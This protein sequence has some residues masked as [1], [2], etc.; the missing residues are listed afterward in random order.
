MSQVHTA[1][2]LPPKIDPQWLEVNLEEYKLLR[3]EL[4]QRLKDADTFNVRAFRL[5]AGAAAAV[6]ILFGKYTLENDAINFE[7]LAQSSAA[8]GW[9]GGAGALAKEVKA[10]YESLVGLDAFLGAYGWHAYLIFF[11]TT[12]FGL[13]I[14]YNYITNWEML[15]KIDHY[16]DYVGS[17]VLRDLRVNG[18]PPICWE[19]ITR[20]QYSGYQ[21]DLPLLPKENTIRPRRGLK[22]LGFWGAAARNRE[23]L[24]YPFFRHGQ[25][26]ASPL[27]AWLAM[28]AI[29]AHI[30]LRNPV[31]SISGADIAIIAVQTLAV[32]AV[33]LMAVLYAVIYRK[34]VVKRANH[35]LSEDERSRLLSPAP[36]STQQTPSNPASGP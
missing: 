9:R 15:R 17:H 27:L 36:S 24:V 32:F 28:A 21:G 26:Y 25:V 35:Y 19:G 31:A 8:T 22:T 2:A 12:I 34:H 13:M 3:E 18:M 20:W 14:A 7:L 10:S 23:N 5:F 33:L 4:N 1:T 16:N 29:T 11:A 6:G 30:L